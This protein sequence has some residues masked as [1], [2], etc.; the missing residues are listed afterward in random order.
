[1]P[2]LPKQD[3]TRTT[4]PLV[5]PSIDAHQPPHK[6]PHPDVLYL[7]ELASDPSNIPDDDVARIWT[8][9]DTLFC[10]LAGTTYVLAPGEDIKY[11]SGSGANPAITTGGVNPTNVVL[12]LDQGE[13][14]VLFLTTF[15][16]ATVSAGV[17]VSALLE[18]ASGSATISQDATNGEAT[19]SGQ[20]EGRQGMAL[21]NVT[22]GPAN[23]RP[24]V[25]KSA[26]GGTYNLDSSECSMLAFRP[27]GGSVGSLGGAGATTFLGLTD[28]P[29]SFSGK[30]GNLPAV[31]SGETALEFIVRTDGLIH[32]D[33]VVDGNWGGA[34]GTAINLRGGGTTKIYSTIQGALSADSANTKRT[35]YIVGG[36][37]AEDITVAATY[38][39]DKDIHIDGE[40]QEAVIIGTNAAD[41]AAAMTLSGANRVWLKRVTLTGGT[42]S[43]GHA[44]TSGASSVRL[45]AEDVSFQEAVSADFAAALF[46]RCRF[47]DDATPNGC[48]DIDAGHSPTAVHFVDCDF[49]GTSTWAGTLQNHLF[50]NCRW[51]DG[52]DKIVST[53]TVTGAVFNGC[54]MDTSGAAKR[55]FHKNGGAITMVL[56][57]CRM[58]KPPDT[59][60]TIYI[61]SASAA[62]VIQVGGCIFQKNST[63][64]FITSDVAATNLTLVNC[65]LESAADPAI[66]G[67]FVNSVFGPNFPPNFDIDT[68]GAS[69]GNLYI[70]TNTGLTD[71]TGT[72]SDTPHAPHVA[73][74]HAQGGGIDLVGQVVELA[75]LVLDDIDAT[76]QGDVLIKNTNENVKFRNAGDTDD[77]SLAAAQVQMSD[78]AY[79][80]NNTVRYGELTLDYAYDGQ[81]GSGAGRNINLVDDKPLTLTAPDA[82]G[83][84]EALYV[85]VS[86]DTFA[87][88]L[89]RVYAGV[90]GLVLGNGSTLDWI[91][92]RTGSDAAELASGD[93]L[94]MDRVLIREIAA[95]STPASGWGTIYFK[96]DGHAYA[97]NDGGTEYLLTHTN[98]A[99]I[100]ITLGIAGELAASDTAD[101]E[102][103]C[104]FKLKL[105]R[106]KMSV[107]VTGASGTLTIDVQTS[108]AAV[109]GVPSFSN[110]TNWTGLTI[111]GTNRTN[112]GDPT[113]SADLAEGTQ[114]R[115]VVNSTPPT[116]RENLALILVAE[117]VP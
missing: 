82:A 88:I 23:I 34:E 15:D 17:I 7:G 85:P 51:S 58:A 68:N 67:V 90:P 13:W 116:G 63:H 29:A 22:S 40:G 84:Y 12:S 27:G 42:N 49:N 98:P 52:A 95:P 41:T 3:P 75:S 2:Q 110:L 81:A 103:I 53:S 96:T 16:A 24:K 71:D 112:A 25:S 8:R 92:T 28:T 69:S 50:T 66:E 59:D 76:P 109:P 44:L 74:D 60:G 21:V 37:Y 38:L 56:A 94:G 91:L 45:E 35:I 20:Y 32:Y 97:K 73:A 86:G 57:N 104:P 11:I 107:K 83:N 30:A 31:N 5:T 106:W 47:G 77:V 48:Y 115:C 87:R 46:T 55:W 36:T 43:G 93:T 1:M 54:T 14:V 100:A 61:Q 62:A 65:N 26:S 114:V 105:K 4:P 117:K 108:A 6:P 70:G 39:A 19:V 99:E 101:F 33:Y 72:S 64:P 113:D 79:F 78:S 10:N 18:V 80:S 102:F 89:L 9:A 111:T